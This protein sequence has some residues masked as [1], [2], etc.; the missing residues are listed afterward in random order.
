MVS[1]DNCDVLSFGRLITEGVVGAQDG[2]ASR[3]LADLDGRAMLR[4][5]GRRRGRS[6][7]DGREGRSKVR[8]GSSL[9]CWGELNERVD[10]GVV[11]L[12]VSVG[13]VAEA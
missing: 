8:A 4:R 7:S 12:Y 2:A 13:K 9:L 11:G 10:N 3:L 1:L 6:W 5:C